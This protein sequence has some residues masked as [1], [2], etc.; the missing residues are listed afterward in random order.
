MNI[1]LLDRWRDC[2]EKATVLLVPLMAS[3]SVAVEPGVSAGAGFREEQ[4]HPQIP[5]IPQIS[6]SDWE[7]TKAV[8]SDPK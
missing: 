1:I 3:G 6:D 8:P 5:Q 4:N 7:G 2:N